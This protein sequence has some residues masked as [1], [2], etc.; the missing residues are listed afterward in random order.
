MTEATTRPSAIERRDAMLQ[1]AA[2]VF[3]E[4]G[5][6]STS[7][8]AIIERLGGSKRAIYAEFGSKEGLFTA[9]VSRSAEFALSALRD[10][11]DG[12][13][14]LI[15][16]RLSVFGRRLM[17]VYFTPALLGVFRAIMTEGLRFPDLARSF[18]DKGPGLA[19]VTLSEVL[20]E[21]GNRGEICVEDHEMAASHFVG[22][23]RDN[24]H[25]GVVLG[26]IPVPSEAEIERHVDSA[27]HI[28]LRGISCAPVDK[29]GP[30]RARSKK[31][32]RP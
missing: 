22:M 27:V 9:L 10:N 26:L 24:L 7:I 23:L 31:A 11:E 4:Q 18:Y 6:A 32:E 28:F 29:G 16:Q 19:V 17:R 21:A 25:L 1:A 8:D 12:D 30:A 20:R 14:M 2:E 3:F 15:Q 5:Y 13:G